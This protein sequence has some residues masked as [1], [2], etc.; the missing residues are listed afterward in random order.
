MQAIRMKRRINKT[1]ILQKYYRGYKDRIRIKL[2]KLKIIECKKRYSLFLKNEIVLLFTKGKFTIESLGFLNEKNNSEITEI[3]L[4]LFLGTKKIEVALI[5]SN[6]LVQKSPN[7]FI[8]LFLNCWISFF[9]WADYGRVGYM[10]ENELQNAFF[11]LLKPMY[12]Y[13]DNYDDNDNY[14]D[15]NNNNNNNNNDDKESNS[16]SNNNYNLK[17]RNRNHINN[18]IIDNNKYNGTSSSVSSDFNYK[19]DKKNGNNN[20]DN[21]NNGDD[22]HN[23]DINYYLIELELTVIKVT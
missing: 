13:F 23:L 9:S 18:I 20:S 17:C 14:S 21:K 3:M 5:L 8:G 10:N 2:L 7:Y 12:N 22:S 6:Y 15:Y 16:N 11:L 4:F 1:I 19:N